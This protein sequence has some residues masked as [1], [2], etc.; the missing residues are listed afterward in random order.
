MRDTPPIAEVEPFARNPGYFPGDM[1]TAVDVVSEVPDVS[2]SWSRSR[3]RHRYRPR[4]T[5]LNGDEA[6]RLLTTAR[7]DRL[8]A[9]YAVALSLGLRRGEALGLRWQDVDLVE[10]VLRVKQTV[11]RLGGK[12]TFGP[13]KSD[14]SERL[15]ALPDHASRR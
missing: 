5:P 13:V 8:Y 6:K 3:A 11:Q 10:G 15:I 7:Q 9:L 1:S 4:F 12:L 2:A 14:G